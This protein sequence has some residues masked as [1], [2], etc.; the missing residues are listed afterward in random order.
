MPEIK[1]RFAPSP[2][3]FVHVGSLRTALYN[4]I[5][6]KHNSGK[7][8]LRIEDTDQSRYVE[9]AIENLL[10]T[11]KWSGILINNQNDWTFIKK[12]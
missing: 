11:M 8:V 7:I 3:G 2:T 5:F 4:Y 9:G 1:V 12:K 6:A 10:D